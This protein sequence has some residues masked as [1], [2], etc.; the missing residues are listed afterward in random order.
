MAYLEN[1]QYKSDNKNLIKIKV[2]SPPQ[3]HKSNVVVKSW[4]AVVGMLVDFFNLNNFFMD[5][6]FSDYLKIKLQMRNQH[7][8]EAENCSNKFLPFF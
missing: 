3:F 4:V 8:D 7:E 6:T 5:C 2:N 1:Y